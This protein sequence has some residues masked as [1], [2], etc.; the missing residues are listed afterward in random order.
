MFAKFSPVN[1]TKGYDIRWVYLTTTGNVGVDFVQEKDLI[2]NGVDIDSL[3][4]F[5][6]KSVMLSFDYYSQF[7]HCN[8]PKDKH[9]FIRKKSINK[10]KWNNYYSEYLPSDY[11]NRQR[12]FI[13]NKF[14]GR[15]VFCNSDKDLN[16]HHR[17]YKNRAMKDEERKDLFLFCR[18][19]HL[20]LHKIVP[21]DGKIRC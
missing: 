14:G 16:V 19:C 17:T 1:N 8:L 13:F 9:C 18:R 15:C 20:L 11:W 6:P 10:M 7:N 5:K 2:S 3:P 21:I 12:R 4:V